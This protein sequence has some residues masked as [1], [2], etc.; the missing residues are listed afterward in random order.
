MTTPN[1]PTM[2]HDSLDAVI[3]GYMLAV[4][5]GEVPNRQDLLDRHPE[6][7]DALRAFFADLDRMDRVASPLRLD[8]GL[9]ATG[10]A[11]ANGHVAPPTVRYF[12]DYELLEEVA[13]GGMGIVYKARQVSLNRLVALK[14]ILAGSF[15]SSRDIQRFRAEA[16]AAA[17]LDHPHI[18]PI[19][20][21]GEHQGQQ[22]YSMKFI[23]GTSLA[24][25]PAGTP[26][27]EVEGLVDVARAVHHAHQ[28]GV[29]H[30]DL[31][32]SNVLVD[33][34]GTRL[35]ADFGLAKRLAAGDGSFTETGQVLGTPK[36]MAPEQAAGRKDLTV[37]ADVYS[38]GVILY[39]RLTGQTPF[40]GDNV[41]TLLR[42]A[43]ELEPLRP[44][45]IRPGLNRDLETVVLKCL[46]KEPGRRYPS[47][48]AL[49]DDLAN[50]LSGR[51]ITA[52][53]VSQAERFWRWCR[54]NPAVAGLTA[55]VASA[56]IL[57]AVVS[58]FFALAERRGRIRA[59]RAEQESERTFAHS[60][61]RPLD[62]DGDEGSDGTLSEPENVALWELSLHQGK[63]IALRFLD[64]A[65]R[66]PLTVRQ[67]RARSEP[68]LVAAVGLDVG[69][70]ERT[71]RLLGERLSDPGRPLWS[72]A[73]VALVALELQ[74]QAGTASDHHAEAIVQAL[75][76]DHPE[77]LMNSW[78]NHLI[79]G[80]AR[81]DPSIAAR[82]LAAV[83][84]R[85]TD[86][87]GRTQMAS[88]LATV[89]RR[90][91]QTEA[92]R[93]CGPAA[94][95]LAKALAV[96]TDVRPRG[97]EFPD[98]RQGA[99]ARA[100]VEM[101]A[102]LNPADAAQML[103]AT[104]LARQDDD[105]TRPTLLDGLLTISARLDPAEAARVCGEVAQRRANALAREKDPGVMVAIE[106][107]LEKVAVRLEPIQNARIWTEISENLANALVRETNARQCAD[108]ASVLGTASARLRPADAGRIRGQTARRLVT[109]LEQE[110][111][112]MACAWLADGLQSVASWMEPTQ[113]PDIYGHAARLLI[114]QLERIRSTD[115]IG[116]MYGPSINS[117]W[118]S[119]VL[120]W[121]GHS[122]AAS[123]VAATVQRAE[124]A[125]VR[126]ALVLNLASMA[127][128]LDAVEARR[129]CLQ[130][131]RSL[132]ATLERETDAGARKFLAEDVVSMVGRL[133]KPKAAQICG[134]AAQVIAI[135]LAHETDA[136][137]RNLL[138][139]AL[140]RVSALLE[141]PEAAR[142]RGE[143]ARALADAL[144]REMGADA[145]NS[146][147]L[148]MV[149]LTG[150]VD[151]SD[152]SSTLAT[153]LTHETD[154]NI[155][156]RLVSLASR[157]DSPVAPQI[158]R[159]AAGVLV[160]ALEHEKD[161]QRCNGLASGL[162]SLAGRLDPPDAARIYGRAA[163]SLAD[164]LARRSNDQVP[165]MGIRMMGMGRMAMVMHMHMGGAGVAPP[166]GSIIGQAL[167]SIAALMAPAEAA[168]ILADALKRA[169]NPASL[170]ELARILSAT[171]DRLDVV[172]ANRLCEDL[173]DSLSRDSFSVIAP[174][175]LKQFNPGRAHAL[176]WEFA[177]SLCSASAVDTDAL[178]RLLTDD[179]REQRARRAERMA[180]AGSGI[181]GAVQAA[182]ISAEPFPCRLTTQELVELLKMPTCF[183]R[184]RRIVLDHLGNRY[185]R[186]FVNHWAFVRYATEQGLGLD[187][188]PPPKRSDDK[189]SLKRMRMRN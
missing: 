149:W 139:A 180:S 145:R 111:D 34:Q 71:V 9:E 138:A 75:T 65:T 140:A 101:A 121:M 146:L 81:F 114:P 89:A 42:Q 88:A 93:I 46:E 47:A 131:T 150:R 115:F 152:I 40:T 183:G 20:E 118:V 25:H 30:R 83:I 67:L 77:N 76:A 58:S 165:A 86:A 171:S 36:Y 85:E 126:H 184:A 15:A 98:P 74:E 148:G 18:V 108:L 133:D 127:D 154:N 90:L 73:E 79:E 70:R 102:R 129:I 49:A 106:N 123:L 43:R 24:N 170:A 181:E 4:E 64:E 99:L 158:Y 177:S 53:P 147:A 151:Q 156:N 141:A 100:L 48:E 35:V 8:G 116:G 21:V 91:T 167:S 22:Y 12:G 173:A 169:S 135:A 161:D 39:E 87:D 188:T 104:A 162:V 29:L 103:L 164:A 52:R 143:A 72:K 62:S 157:P 26:R 107:E 66:D 168:H 44:S 61:A 96:D 11:E 17:N 1:D 31:K 130:V 82:L 37:A 3:A 163:H 109:A 69:R 128:R 189:G 54:R 136:N 19:Y 174:E 38:L 113:A 119:V 84:E 166:R 68:A 14:M 78:R 80:S 159:Q 142:I 2:S 28:R 51:P 185:R 33:S 187:F 186:H 60:L 182:R 120:N 175:L 132:T 97:F 32:P 94:K 124:N 134:R 56:L 23:V 172:Q 57:G 16:E 6:H 41:L 137:A 125:E 27:R 110:T 178:S 50:W 95:I 105:S 59:E 122:E 117:H 160:A 155:R 5:G 63:P 176:A 92:A 153:A 144:D 179:A 112:A 10:A 7:A 55:A 13:R 45:L